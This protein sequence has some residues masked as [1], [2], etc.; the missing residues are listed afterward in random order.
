MT[1]KIWWVDGE[2]LPLEECSKEQ[3]IA[4]FRHVVN[5]QEDKRV[6]WIGKEKALLKRIQDFRKAKT[7]AN[8]RA[9]QACEAMKRLIKAFEERKE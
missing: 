3:L 2:C 4:R 1:D 6:G 7:L 8:R 5:R 9:D